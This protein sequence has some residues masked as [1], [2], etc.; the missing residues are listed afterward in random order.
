MGGWLSHTYVSVVSATEEQNLLLIHPSF[1]EFFTERLVWKYAI[2]IHK[3]LQTN[4][5]V[6]EEFVGGLDLLVKTV[7][8]VLLN[9]LASNQRQDDT[10]HT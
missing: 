3:I 5:L 2:E 1:L 10:Y 4:F 7:R 9:M 6:P 8:V